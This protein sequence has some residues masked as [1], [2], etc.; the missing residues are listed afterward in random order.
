MDE[1]NQLADHIAKLT[2]E[3]WSKARAQ[4]LLRHLK[5]AQALAAAQRAARLRKWLAKAS[6]AERQTAR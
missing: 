3:R 5:P 1:A 2:Q 4:A 6:S